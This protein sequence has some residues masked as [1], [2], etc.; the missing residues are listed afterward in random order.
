[1]LSDEYPFARV[2]VIFQV[3]SYHFV[4][5]ESATSSIRVNTNK[6]AVSQE[7]VSYSFVH[8]KTFYLKICKKLF[9]CS[10]LIWVLE[11]QEGKTS[12]SSFL[13]QANDKLSST[14]LYILS[15]SS[16]IY[17]KQNVVTVMDTHCR[18]LKPG[19]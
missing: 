13:N 10:I 2:S 14:H 19:L 8:A 17:I 7:P 4:L 6:N 12:I 5:A 11:D 15:T 16:I 18:E 3:F 9:Q 1:M